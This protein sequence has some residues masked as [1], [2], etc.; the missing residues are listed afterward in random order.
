MNLMYVIIDHNRLIDVTIAHN[1][2]E[3]VD[4]AGKW[5][6]KGTSLS[7][8]ISKHK[9]IHLSCM[10]MIA[11]FQVFALSARILSEKENALRQNLVMK[12]ASGCQCY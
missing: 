7:K 8:K 1:T 11:C 12:N 5:L 10:A 2:L 3:F 4:C 6:I 9:L